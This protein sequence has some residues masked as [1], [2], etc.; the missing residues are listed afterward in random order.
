MPKYHEYSE[1]NAQIHAPEELKARVLRVARESKTQTVEFRTKEVS[2]QK[3]PGRYSR[4][5]SFLQKAAVAAVLTL[6]IPATAYAAAKQFG[7][8]EHFGKF[9]YFQNTQELQEMVETFPG[10]AAASPEVMENGEIRIPEFRVTEALCDDHA[11][12]V[13]TEIKP[14]DD[15]YLLVPSELDQYMDVGN[16]MIPGVSGMSIEDYAASLDKEI[17][18]VGT[19]LSNDNEHGVSAGLISECTEDGVVYQYFA[20]ENMSDLTEFP[21]S[22]TCLYHTLDMP[23]AERFEFDVQITNKSQNKKVTTFTQFEDPGMGVTVH[24]LTLEETEIGVYAE[25]VFSCADG[26]DFG[27]FDLRDANG[28]YLPYLALSGNP[29]YEDNEDGTYTSKSQYKNMDSL[30]G[31]TYRFARAE[32]YERF[33]PFK[34]LG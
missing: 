34:I 15:R 27:F 32:D 26:A 25:F 30:E 7:I 13:A 24:S 9:G 31:L 22:V 6:C 11:L 21:L 18:F 8:L 5:F 16:M 29:I 28:E 17:L 20:G 23:L 2:E 12:Y 3:K 33:G 1:L 10:E 14:M 19:R 4:G